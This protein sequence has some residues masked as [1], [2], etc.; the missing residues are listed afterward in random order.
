MSN[1]LSSAEPWSLVAAGYKRTTQTYLE[2]YSLK[3]IELL[4]PARSD[5]VLDVATGSGTL[6]LPLARHVAE[7][8]AIDF[9]ENMIAELKES[10]R[11]RGIENI[12]PYL[13]DGQ[14]LEFPDN[15]FDIAFSM[16]GLMFFPDKLQGMREIFRVLKPGKRAA[17]SSWGPVTNSPMMQ[18]MFGAIRAALPETPAPASSIASLENPDFFRDQLEA[19]QFTDIEIIPAAPEFRITN[20]GEFFDSMIEGSA[21]IQLMKQ[22]MGDS[23][24]LEK[25]KVMRGFIEEQLT[26]PAVVY[27]EANLAIARKPG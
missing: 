9:S 8:H 24:W 15:H 6:A 3:A 19:A 11:E 23:V 25:S 17:I 22:R 10:I 20:A 7:I 2:P 18:L 13:M 26:L 12:R 16:F 27:S 14:K 1:P 21:P 4:G 5:R